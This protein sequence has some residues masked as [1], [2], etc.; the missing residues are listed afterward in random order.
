[1]VEIRQSAF[2]PSTPKGVRT[3]ARI[4]DAARSIFARDGFVETRMSDVAGAA[5][6]S[7]GGLYRYFMSKED[8][9]AALIADLLADLFEA[10]GHTVHS[11]STDPFEALLEA[12]RGYL[13]VYHANRDVMRAFVEAVAVDKRF[14]E[15]F[16]VARRRHV[17]RFV[18]AA[19][20]VHGRRKVD[21]VE[22]ETVVEAMACMV[23]QSAYLWFAQEALAE[24]RVSVDDAARVVTRAWYLAI[25]NGA[26]SQRA[27]ATV[28]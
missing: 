17:S 16:W 11:F 28:S 10:S 20:S 8:V 13:A 21:G 5:G 27:G 18:K 3:R 14:R 26:A 19:R 2:R 22:L 25:F 24:R 23:E 6:L 12:N 4:L 7:A 15:M 1:M 9:F